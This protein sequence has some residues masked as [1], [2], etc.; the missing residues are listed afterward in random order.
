VALSRNRI[1]AFSFQLS[2]V[3][4]ARVDS[5]PPGVKL[6]PV[7]DSPITPTEPGIREE[8]LRDPRYPVHRIADRLLPYLRIL[9]EQFH[10]R[11]VILFGSYANGQPDRHSDVDLIIVKDRVESPVRDL[12]AIQRAWRSIRWQGNSLPFE[13]VLET[14]ADHEERAAKR[15]SFY[16]DAVRSGLRLA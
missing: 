15:G 13:L 2:A 5:F 16:A 14:P 7:Q 12:A 6:L 11:Q 3:P 4:H 8:T 10:P 1:S 9:V